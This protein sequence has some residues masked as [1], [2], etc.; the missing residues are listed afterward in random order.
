MRICFELLKFKVIF[1]RIFSKTVNPHTTFKWALPK[2]PGKGELHQFSHI[3][4][5][6]Q[7]LGSTTAY[8]M[9]IMYKVWF[10][11][12]SFVSC[13]RLQVWKWKESGGVE[14]LLIS[15]WGQQHQGITR[16]LRGTKR[17]TIRLV[18][19]H[20]LWSLFLNC[21]YCESDKVKRGAMLNWQS[22]LLRDPGN[23]LPLK[24]HRKILWHGWIM[25]NLTVACLAHVLYHCCRSITNACWGTGSIPSPHAQVS[26]QFPQ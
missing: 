20:Q 5:S 15:A 16:R 7:V 3:T 10:M 8:S 25:V 1:C 26:S 21:L 9:W 19:L 24:C 18:L 14:T 22:P 6:L 23:N 2:W 17:R 4:V 13:W 12:F 11:F